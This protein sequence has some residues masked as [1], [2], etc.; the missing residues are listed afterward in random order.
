MRLMI[1]L[2]GVDV[3]RLR[4]LSVLHLAPGAKPGRL[5]IWGRSAY[6]ALERRLLGGAA[7]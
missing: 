7:G 3:I 5:V 6:E 4:D 2:P 1:L